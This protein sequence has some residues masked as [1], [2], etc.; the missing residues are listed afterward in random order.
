MKV[1][2]EKEQRYKCQEDTCQEDG[3]QLPAQG[4]DV[5]IKHSLAVI[6]GSVIHK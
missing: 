2:E 3:K 4:T 6:S 1:I 5:C